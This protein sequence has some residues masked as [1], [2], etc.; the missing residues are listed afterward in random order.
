MEFLCS[1]ITRINSTNDKHRFSALHQ[2]KCFRLMFSR[3]TSLVWCRA[4]VSRSM[5]QCVWERARLTRCTLAGRFRS[6]RGEP[7]CFWCSEEVWS[8]GEFEGTGR[9]RSSRWGKWLNCWGRLHDE[10]MLHIWSHDMRDI[11]TWQRDTVT[12]HERM[13]KLTGSGSG[14]IGNLNF[15]FSRFSS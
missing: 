8:C 4:D 6:R 12:W 5:Q 14:Q 2:T 3:N 1:G 11:V 15:R 10:N 13:L 7:W 9:L